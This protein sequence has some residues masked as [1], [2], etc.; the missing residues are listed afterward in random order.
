MR[1]SVLWGESVAHAAQ[2]DVDESIGERR[3]GQHDDTGQSQNSALDQDATTPSTALFRGSEALERSIGQ[4]GQQNLPIE[5]ELDEKYD[6][7]QL[8]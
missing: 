2:F 8:H 3:G 7:R 5:A 1:K 4:R 6:W